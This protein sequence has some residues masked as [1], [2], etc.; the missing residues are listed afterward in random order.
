MELVNIGWLALFTFTASLGISFTYLYKLNRNKK[1]LMFGIS[2]FTS[3]ICYLLVAFDVEHLYYGIYQWTSFPMMIAILICAAEGIFKIKS[4]TKLFKAFLVT[5]TVILI[6]FLIL[7]EKLVMYTYLVRIPL[8]ASIMVMLLYLSISERELSNFLFLSAISCYIIAGISQSKGYLPLSLYSYFTGYV[9]ISLISFSEQQP[10]RHGVSTFLNMRRELELTR[11]KLSKIAEE[12]KIII[13]NIPAMVYLK[14]EKN[15]FVRV[16]KAFCEFMCKNLSI[17]SDNIIGKRAEDI[18]PQKYL[19]LFSE[20][21][22]VLKTGQ[23]KLDILKGLNVDGKSIWLNINKIPYNAYGKV[24]GLVCIAYDVTESIEK[25]R[26]LR[27]SRERFRTLAETS[28]FAIIVYQIE[29][30][31]YANHA[32]E[33]ITGFSKG[34]LIRKKFWELIHPEFR[35][36]VRERSLE[37]QKGKE[38]SPYECKI[39]TK[40]GSEKWIRITGSRIIWNGMPAGIV[41]AVDITDIKNFENY[42]K[43]SERRF[44]VLAESS[45]IDILVIQDGRFVFA[46]FD[47]AKV[48][49]YSRKEILS[50]NFLDMIHPEF[51][52]KV[53]K[54]YLDLLSG[55]HVSPMECKILDKS[56]REK[57][58]LI[59]GNLIDWEGKPSILIAVTDITDRKK[60]EEEAIRAKRYMENILHAAGDGIRIIGLDYKVKMLNRRMARMAKVKMK[61]GLGMKCYEMFRADICRTEDCSLRRVLRTGRGFQKESLR[62][63]TDGKAIP[64]LQMVTPLKD[65]NGNIVGIIEDFRDIRVIKKA[66]E[67]L[68]RAHEMLKRKKEQLEKLNNLKSLFLNITSHELRTPMTAI[69]GYAQLL[70]LGA[71]GKIDEE[72]KKVLETIIRN[73]DRLNKL[74]NDILDVSRLESG[75]LKITPEKCRIE[76]IIDN[77]IETMNGHAKLKNIKI[78]KLVEYD[79]PELFL[80][81]YRMEQVVTNLLNNAIKFSNRNSKIIVRARREGENVILEIQDF[82]RGIPKNKLSKIF[83]PFYQVD[84]GM[85]RKFGGAGLGLTIVK[86]IVEG[87][88]GSVEVESKVGEGSTFRVILPIRYVGEER[89]VKILTVE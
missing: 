44:R 47:I 17:K 77:A 70:T 54:K 36:V 21:E 30:I 41:T 56:G 51:K 6:A 39:I 16:N 11:R 12:Q 81:K 78:E 71:L 23:P 10:R 74:I 28:P 57:W 8:T 82:G 7:P 32:A 38:I 24:K 27:E 3:S 62:Y 83:E 15:R 50:K 22:L 26:L 84:S 88:G 48:T 37:R 19:S 66:E 49:G 73:I 33:I 58:A 75:T 53:Q 34:E 46:N 63:S 5:I 65:S 59:G 29:D 18:F 55:K 25:E 31:V 2:F 87:H 4:F 72:Q 69:R 68:R 9:F 76:E 1:M 64:C 14:D 85:D 43:E 45:P 67:R 80:D 42:L 20:D 52:E 89:K 86:G 79:L 40:D 13:E 61:E 60:A 35:E